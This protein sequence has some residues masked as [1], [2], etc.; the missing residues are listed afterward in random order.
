MKRTAVKSTSIK[1]VGY[2]K[3]R[4]VLEVQFQT[5]SIY[6]YKGVPP[7]VHQA[8]MATDSKG[9]YFAANIRNV[10]ACEVV[11]GRQLQA[12]RQP[13]GDWVIGDLSALCDYLRQEH[14]GELPL[15]SELLGT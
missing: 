10:Y 13:A 15:A 7:E 12:P 11:Q 6:Q 14:G 4:Q 1:S 5:G 2:A 8:L 3:R 9:K